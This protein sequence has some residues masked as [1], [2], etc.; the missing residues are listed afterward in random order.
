L[1][2]HEG[3]EKYYSLVTS[4]ELIFWMATNFSI[5]ISELIGK[6]LVMCHQRHSKLA[7]HIQRSSDQKMAT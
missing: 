5:E 2:L 7:K 1:N 3:S 4:N 6:V